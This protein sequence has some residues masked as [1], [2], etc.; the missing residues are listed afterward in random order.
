MFGST[1][2]ASL[3]CNVKIGIFSWQW[4]IPPPPSLILTGKAGQVLPPKPGKSYRRG[5]ISTVDLLVLTNLGQLLLIIQTFFTFY[6]TNCLNDEV[7]CAEPSPSVSVPAQTLDRGEIVCQN[8]KH[9]LGQTSVSRMNET[10]AEFS[11]LA[12]GTC[13]NMEALLKGKAQY[14]WPPCAY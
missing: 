6:E 10:L 2:V 8:Q 9:H 13:W 14:S 1:N 4:K 3:S 11:T 12:M 5:R 7:N